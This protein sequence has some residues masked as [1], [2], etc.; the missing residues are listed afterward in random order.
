MYQTVY[1]FIVTSNTF[2]EQKKTVAFKTMD[3]PPNVA[4]PVRN[5]NY[6]ILPGNTSILFTWRPPS[7]DE[8]VDYYEVFL[9]DIE[10]K[11]NKSDTTGANVTEWTVD[12]DA[13]A[14][15]QFVVFAYIKNERNEE[16]SRV[17]N[18]PVVLPGPVTEVEDY[19]TSSLD[20]LST[21]LQVVWEAPELGARCSKFYMIQF[22]RKHPRN[23]TENRQDLNVTETKV[24]IINLDA[25]EIYF[26]KITPAVDDEQ[27]GEEIQIEINVEGREPMMPSRP[28]RAGG[29]STTFKFFVKREDISTVC[30]L[31]VAKFVCTYQGTD[32]EIQQE[33]V[34]E[35][36]IDNEMME[37]H[38]T[39]E[40]L[41]PFSM[42]N[43]FAQLRNEK[44]WSKQGADQNFVTDEDGKKF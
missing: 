21:T 41:E 15:Y 25:C 13:C 24:T 29:T 33:I 6:T 38:T 12:A 4:G 19:S 39:I 37:Y 22:W 30:Q 1:D 20:P 8:V 34:E 17:V 35:E 26:M 23:S 27:Y 14:N 7:D 40:G 42:Y 36:I 9:N 16:A 5:V 10:M 2:P 18:M 32:G 44:G 28:N 3:P 31:Y 11:T 43:C